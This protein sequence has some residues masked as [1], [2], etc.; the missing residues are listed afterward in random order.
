MK[1]TASI[2]LKHLETVNEAY[3]VE[4]HTLQAYIYFCQLVWAPHQNRVFTSLR[5]NHLLNPLPSTVA[6]AVSIIDVFTSTARLS[7]RLLHRHTGGLKFRRHVS[8][9]SL[10]SCPRAT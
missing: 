10:E 8:S 3:M 5:S 7:N 4:G 2:G 9:H 6:L 1:A